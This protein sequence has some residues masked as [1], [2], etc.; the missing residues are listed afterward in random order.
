M[1]MRVRLERLSQYYQNGL[2]A[3]VADALASANES[4]GVSDARIDAM[5]SVPTASE[6]AR[7]SY[8]STINDTYDAAASSELRNMLANADIEGL[9]DYKE[10][11]NPAFFSVWPSGRRL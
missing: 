4:L 7:F 2:T 6:D 9:I 3:R 11:I 1:E 10:N 8:L 5:N